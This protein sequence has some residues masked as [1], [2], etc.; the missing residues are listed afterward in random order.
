MVTEIKLKQVSAATFLAR[1]NLQVYTLT[2]G[3][4]LS[5]SFAFN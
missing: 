5:C 1:N 2:I 4:M 3:V